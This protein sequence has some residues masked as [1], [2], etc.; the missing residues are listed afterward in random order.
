MP[1]INESAVEACS[2]NTTNYGLCTGT[3]LSG[4]ANL[5]TVTE[6]AT[7]PTYFLGIVGI[8]SIPITTVSEASARGGP[9]QALHVEIIIDATASMSSSIDNGCGLGNNAT[10]EQC[11]LAGVQ[12]MLQGMNPTID[13]VGILTFPGVAAA[14]D[15]SLDYTCGKSLPSSDTQPYNFGPET[16][17]NPDYQIISISGSKNFKTSFTAKTLNPNSNVAGA[18]DD[19]GCSSGIDAAGGQGTYIAEAIVQAQQ[20]LTAYNAPHAQNVIVL[21]SDGGA[22][23]TNIQVNFNGSIAVSSPVGGPTTT[24]LTVNSVSA[25]TGSLSVGQTIAGSGIAAGTTIT[26]LGTGTGGTGTYVLSNGTA[27]VGSRSMTAANNVLINGNTY[28]Q[29]VGQCWQAIQAAEAA[30]AAGTWVYSLAYGSS[31]STS[32]SDCT[33]DT[34]PVISSC[35]EMADIASSLAGQPLPS[36]YTNNNGGVD[37]PG[38]APV[39]N[40]V[41]LFTNLGQTLSEPH[42]L[43]PG[44]S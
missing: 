20:D 14:A 43:P 9:Q 33:T 19:A 37:C 36:F 8:S 41:T 3:E 25:N 21:L 2:T 26:A 39:N 18:L 40:L 10:R 31:T 16:G 29:N 6:T 34:S 27:A 7:V 24:T 17:N 1:T 32:P 42:L 13:Y 44:T 28:T 15:A 35:T 22:N 4:G 30:S 38:G 12:A 5:I 23:S 11:A